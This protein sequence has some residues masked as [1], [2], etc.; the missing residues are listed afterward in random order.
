ML[1]AYVR[2]RLWDDP[3]I[4][5]LW[6]KVCRVMD[7]ILHVGSH[8]TGTSTL[9]S[10]LREHSEALTR[11]RTAVWD[12]RLTRRGLFHGLRPGDAVPFGDRAR[13]RAIGR[14]RLNLDAAEKAGIKTLIVTDE[15][16]VGSVRENLQARALYPSVGERVARVCEAFEGYVSAVV[17]S[18]RAQDRYWPSACAYGVAVGRDVPSAQTRDYIARSRRGWADVI[19]DLACAAP[20]N[21]VRIL[22]FELTGGDPRAVLTRGFGLGAQLPAGQ[23]WI[24]RAP[25]LDQLREIL[26][27]RGEDPQ[28]LPGGTGRWQPFDETQ[29]TNMHEAYLD[30]LHWLTSGADGLVTLIEEDGGAQRGKAQ[31]RSDDRGPGDE[32]EERHLA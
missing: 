32:Q 13:R 1:S 5:A 20:K 28:Q 9:Q 17:F 15:N 31:T 25:G 12:P 14:I 18:I 22:P 23:D 24:N 21:T 19:S 29:L 7:V 3:A 6:S 8:R 30:D 2:V 16:I 26:C 27:A 11:S 10:Y 4:P